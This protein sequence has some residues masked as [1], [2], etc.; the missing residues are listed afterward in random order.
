VLI[1]LFFLKIGCTSVMNM[2]KN[3]LF[4]FLF[5]GFSCIAMDNS[6]EFRHRRTLKEAAQQI[7]QN[8]STS[9]RSKYKQIIENPDYRYR[10]RDYIHCSYWTT[11]ISSTSLGLLCMLEALANSFSFAIQE[12]CMACMISRRLDLQMQVGSCL[13]L[14]G[15]CMCFC[16]GGRNC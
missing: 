2:C 3:L 4:S 1:Q 14:C 6:N 11:A 12:Q 7:L 10:C 8:S 16:N 9:I 5:C 15:F 13:Y